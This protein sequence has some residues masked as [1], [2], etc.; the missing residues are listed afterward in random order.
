[1]KMA[2]TCAV[3]AVL[4]GSAVSV[5]AQTSSQ[6]GSQQPPQPQGTIRVPPNLPPPVS[7][8]RRVK[9]DDLDKVL[10]DG[11]VILLDVREPWE[12]E[13]FGTREGYINIPLGELEKRLNELP[14]E[15]TILTA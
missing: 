13:K 3:I 8:E 2:I 4:I 6:V 7:E 15:K 12:L 1:M 11:S 10:G 5:S 14:K 9:G